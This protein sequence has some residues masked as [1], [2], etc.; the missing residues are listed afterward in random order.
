MTSAGIWSRHLVDALKEVLLQS[1]VYCGIPA[2][3]A[4]FRVAS[5]VLAG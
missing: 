2:A 5:E 4:A 3:N 1:A